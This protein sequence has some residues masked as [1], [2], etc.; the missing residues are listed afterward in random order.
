MRGRNWAKE[1]KGINRVLLIKRDTH[2]FS[3]EVVALV[4]DTPGCDAKGNDVVARLCQR[5]TQRVANMSHDT[6]RRHQTKRRWT[7]ELEKNYE[8]FKEHHNIRLIMTSCSC[9]VYGWKSKK[10]RCL[11]VRWFMFEQNVSWVEVTI[12][13][14]KRSLLK[15]VRREQLLWCG[16]TTRGKPRNENRMDR[17]IEAVREDKICLTRLV[18]CWLTVI[19]LQ[20]RSSQFGSVFILLVGGDV[21]GVVMSIRVTCCMTETTIFIAHYNNN[22]TTHN[23]CSYFDHSLVDGG[24]SMKVCCLLL[25]LMTYVRAKHS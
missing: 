2:I 7:T 4:N 8:G 18:S 3:D 14:G 25:C 9:L 22:Y 24:E 23:D 10:V 16:V 19:Q 11:C 20:S 5:V 15:W 17:R 21:G 13:I 1:C 12:T 6:Y